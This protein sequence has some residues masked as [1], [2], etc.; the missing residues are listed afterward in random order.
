MSSSFLGVSV[1]FAL[2]SFGVDALSWESARKLCLGSGGR[3]CLYDRCYCDPRC[4]YT[5]SFTFR[6]LLTDC[7][8]S[9]FGSSVSFLSQA[10]NRCLNTVDF[11]LFRVAAGILHRKCVHV[12]P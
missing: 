8:H 1:S 4:L 9:W 10:A 12:C 7:S 5:C 6:Q 2:I 3:T 11:N